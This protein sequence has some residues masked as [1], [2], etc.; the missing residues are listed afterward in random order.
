VFADAGVRPVILG[1]TVTGEARDVA[2]VMA[3]LVRE[4]RSHGAPFAPPVALISGG[5]CTVTLR[6]GG[7]GRVG[8]AR[9]S[10]SRCC[11]SC[12][13]RPASTRSPP[14]PTA[15]TAWSRMPA[16]WLRPD[17]AARALA[18]GLDR[19]RALDDHD[20][21]GFF[22]ALDDLVTTG[23]TRTNVNDYRAVVVA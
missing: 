2:Q 3:A 6:G 17:S 4:V 15:S 14:T 18:L 5:E 12:P 16:H 8:A 22:A 23:P 7:G 1:D 19:R 9:S 11:P 10:C 20:A 21:F 13:A